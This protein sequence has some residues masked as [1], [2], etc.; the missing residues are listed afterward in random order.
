M[1]PGAGLPEVGWAF[2]KA[3]KKLIVFSFFLNSIQH[4]YGAQHPPFD[5]LVHGT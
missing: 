5:P 1:F 4:V 3:G 2:G